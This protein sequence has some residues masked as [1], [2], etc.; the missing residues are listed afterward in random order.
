MIAEQEVVNLNC[1]ISSGSL[2]AFPLCGKS[3]NVG[4]FCFDWNVRELSGNF[5]VSHRIERFRML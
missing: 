2:T 4:E 3:G 5:A 1:S